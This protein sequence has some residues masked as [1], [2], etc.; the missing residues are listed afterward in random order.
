MPKPVC[1][2]GLLQRALGKL[3]RAMRIRS[4]A[5]D[6]A[7]CPVASPQRQ[8]TE[9]DVGSACRRKLVI[10]HDS[11]GAAQRSRSGNAA[12]CWTAGRATCGRG[13]AGRGKCRRL[14]EPIGLADTEEQAIGRTVIKLSQ[15]RTL[16][17][18]G[19]INHK[20]L[21]I[22][23]GDDMA[24]I[25]RKPIH[26]RV[27][28]YQGLFGAARNESARDDMS[29]GAAV[30]PELIIESSTVHIACRAIASP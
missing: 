9:I 22:G 15:G 23:V 28:R 26:L 5:R 19:G 10:D 12:G 25:E 17:S 7:L 14:H 13:D 3:D 30:E 20:C 8:C 6:I 18:D 1:L 16:V 11:A 24:R 4:A 21:L 29:S 27:R 2:S